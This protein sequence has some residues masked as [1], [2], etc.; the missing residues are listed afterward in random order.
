MTSQH[1]TPVDV[2]VL[3]EDHGRVLLTQ[4]AGDIP[5][6]GEW[7]L[8]S[9]GVE[10]DEDVISAVRR[11]LTEELGISVDPGDV[12]FVGVT[13][14]RPPG[15]DARIGFGFVISRWAGD[16]EIREPERCSGLD[17]R[18]PSDLPEPTMAYTREILRLHVSGEG[19][20][21]R[22]WPPHPAPAALP[23]AHATTGEDPQ[24]V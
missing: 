13:H 5:G 14:A 18:A 11:E 10:A 19:L 23:A 16:P 22:G 1:R 3:L 4:R 12:Q 7:A 2:L 17:W 9:G 21:V 24:P 20:S 6:T 15:G 8:P